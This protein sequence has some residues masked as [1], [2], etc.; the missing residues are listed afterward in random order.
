MTDTKT[1][2]ERLYWIDQLRVLACFAVV[3]LHVSGVAV[4]EAKFASIDWHIGNLLDSATRWSVPVF[5]L[6]S[7]AL[8]LNPARSIPP[9]EFYKQR[10]TRL[11]IP[12]L[13][14]TVLYLCLLTLLSD[15]GLTV[16]ERIEA[17]LRGRFVHIWFLYMIFGLYLVTPFLQTYIG[18]STFKERN[19]LLVVLFIIATAA[20]T[21]NAFLEKTPQSLAITLFV[22]FTLYY[23]AGYQLLAFDAKSISPVYLWGG[24]IVAILAVAG[25]TY[26]FV[27][28][29]DNTA[30]GRWLYRYLSPPVIVMALGI[31]MLA[32]KNA[33]NIKPAN[34]ATRKI[35]ESISAA[36][37]GI[38]LIH[39]LFLSFLDRFVFSVM[40]FSALISIPITTIIIFLLSYIAI[41][42]ISKLPFVKLLVV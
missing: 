17:L 35:V 19:L 2:P 12:T 1:G 14:W 8:L 22:P 21:L 29:W 30:R 28:Y 10:I 40:D 27:E 34:S 31:F 36:T 15:D 23:V 25:G 24:V 37:L 38:Y 42:I 7:G 13:G 4:V 18:A 20:S 26:L 5:V 9:L 41:Y 16:Q 39:P 3:L 33:Q 6:I 32:L 11:I